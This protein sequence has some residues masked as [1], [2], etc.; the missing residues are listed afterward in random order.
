MASPKPAQTGEALAFSPGNRKLGKNCIVWSRPVGPTCPPNCHFHPDSDTEDKCY[1]KQSEET[2]PPALPFASR[3]L[4]TTESR[5]RSTL[6]FAAQRGLSVRIHE[7][8]DF[9]M[10]GAVDT[11]YVMQ[12]VRACQGILAQGRQLP[13]IWSYTHIIDSPWLVE[14]ISP[15]VTL[16]ASVHNRQQLRLARKTGFTHF[17]HVDT[18]HRYAGRRKGGRDGGHSAAV[19]STR[20]DGKRFIICPAQRRSGKVTCTGSADSLACNACAAGVNVVFLHH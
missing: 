12:I 5:I 6:L 8:G 7:G 15:F 1:R 2:Y 20:I 4:I 17:A 3:N 10:N 16:Y 9:W 11:E 14:Q 13:R 19:K 18:Q